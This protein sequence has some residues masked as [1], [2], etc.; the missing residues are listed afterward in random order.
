MLGTILELHARIAIAVLIFNTFVGLWGIV[1][2]LQGKGID[3][4]Y[5]GAV[6]LSPILGLVQMALGL[7]MVANGLYVNVRFVH[8]L[9]GALVIIAAPACF[10]F[11]RGRDDRG[12]QLIFGLIL[13]LNAGF[14][15]RAYTT[16]VQGNGLF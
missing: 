6:A 9:Y 4:S 10:M 7:I 5:W 15:V 14:G 16:G 2:F 3:G 13:L 1:R 11:L 8:Y 12:A